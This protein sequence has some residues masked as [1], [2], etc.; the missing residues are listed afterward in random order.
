MAVDISDLTVRATLV[1]DMAA[2]AA[3]ARSEIA[4][5]AAETEALNMKGAKVAGETGGLGLIDARLAMVTKSAVGAGSKLQEIGGSIFEKATAGA[6]R[7][8]EALGLV[9]GS[10]AA[11]GVESAMQTSNLT[12]SLTTYLGSAQQAATVTSQI[13]KMALGPMSVNVLGQANTEFLSAG[14]NQDE[15]LKLLSGV[16]NIAAAQSGNK[17]QAVTG[18]SSALNQ[19]I[20]SQEITGRQLK[21]FAPYFDVYGMMS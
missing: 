6:K 18:L 13:R 3:K 16:Q 15:S 4:S 21:Q 11:I 7:L 5:I 1:S 10:L 19:V 14:M 2:G 8:A 12:T 17:G 9:Q 20:G